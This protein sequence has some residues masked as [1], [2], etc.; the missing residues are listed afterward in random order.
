M[1][2]AVEVDSLLLLGAKEKGIFNSTPG[3]IRE[4][5]NL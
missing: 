1:K 2:C 4:E 3:G 5:K